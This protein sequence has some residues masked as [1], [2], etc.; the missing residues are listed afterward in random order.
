M[1]RYRCA[2]CDNLLVAPSRWSG[3]AAA[4][5]RCANSQA[6]P[7]KDDPLAA[8]PIAGAEP[9]PDGAGAY[10]AMLTELIRSAPAPKRRRLRRAWI[11]AIL[12]VGLGATAFAGWRVWRTRFAP[13]AAARRNVSASHRRVAYPRLAQLER[14]NAANPNDERAARRLAAAYERVIEDAGP[15]GAKGIPGIYN[16][17]AWLYATTPIESVR[18]VQ[19]A[20]RYAETAVRLT[21]GEDATILDTLAEALH[22]D[23]RHDEA[24]RA[25]EKAVAMRPDMAVLKKHLETYRAAARAP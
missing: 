24:V 5:P 15:N 23:G 17:A 16:N 9:A 4:C 3:R 20:L 14:R 6:V 11:W 18:D 7:S 21:K 12:V 10:D 19:R 25:A 22:R 13:E 2:S 8:R 1:L